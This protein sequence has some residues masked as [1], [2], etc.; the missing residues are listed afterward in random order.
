ME[1]ERMRMAGDGKA[2][3][4]AGAWLARLRSELRT[5]AD[6][7][8]FQAWLADDARHQRAFE[9][10]TAAYEAAGA[11]A[12]ASDLDSAS[13]RPMVGRR[14]LIAG[15]VTLAAVAATTGFTLWGGND[16]LLT[17]ETGQ[18][19][20]LA[21]EDGSRLML[22]TGSA[23]RV[24]LTGE[25]RLVK[26]TSGRARFD[27]ARDAARPFIV[28]AGGQEVIAIGTAFTVSRLDNH[29][30]V[31]LE[32]GKVV[33]REQAPAT[34][35]ADLAERPMS[36]GDRLVFDQGNPVPR[37]DRPDLAQATAWERGRAIFENESL[38]S[39][40]E[41]IN[42][43][44]RRTIEIADRQ[45]ADL[46]VSGV[47]RTN[48]PESFAQSVALLLPVDVLIAEDGIVLRPRNKNLLR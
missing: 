20:R 12:T 36:P 42:R 43:Y 4:E 26:L 18:Q 13:G 7:L 46:K 2:R 29:V 10:V 1:R 15:G 33:V 48:D 5:P 28:R 11:V 40:V 34:N 47:F 8:G 44:N 23:A 27:V 30:S 22:D 17:T 32:E 39:A 16:N 41:E 38:S 14:Q 45:V 9:A 19:R 31:F 37:H 25:R 35:R 3:A 24:T 21:L 6:E